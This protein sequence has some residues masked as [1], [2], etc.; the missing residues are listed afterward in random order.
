[1]RKIL[2]SAV[3][4]IFSTIQ[5]TA[6]QKW[7]RPMELKNCTIDIKADQFTATTFIEMEFCNP[8]NSEIEG[9]HRFK[10]KPGQIITAFQ[11]DLNGKYRD[12]SIEEKW[13]A[14]NAYNS[15]VGKRIDPALLTMDYAGHYTL[16]IYPVPAKGC[17]KVTM[18]IQ[19]LLTTERKNL[20]YYLPLN[21]ND[22]VQNFRLNISVNGNANPFAKTGLIA[23]RYFTGTGGKYTLNWNTENIL[24]KNPIA[25]SMP[26]STKPEIC[27]RTNE[28]QTFFALRLQ[29]SF[30]REYAIQPKQLTVFWD[31][32]ASLS[33]R[34]VNKEISFLKQFISRHNIAQLTIIP[35]NYK[36]L[37]S[38]IFF[39][40]NGFNSR[41]Q[42]YL[43]NITYDGATQLGIIDLSTI[44]SDIVLLFTDGNNTYGKSKPKTGNTIV[45]C[46]HTSSTANLAS[47]QQIV[48][49]SG[50]KVIDLNRTSISTAVDIGSKSENWLLNITSVAGKTIVEQAMPVKQEGTLFINGTMAPGTDTL[51]FLY[52]SNGRVNHIEKIAIHSNAECPSS[53]IDRINMLNNFDYIIRNYSWSNIIDFGIQEKVVTPHTAYIVLERV[54][55]YVK[56]NIAPP[57][58]LEAECEKMNYVKRDTRFERKK[59]EEAGEFDILK[60]VVNV[61]NERIKRWDKKENLL[62]LDKSEYE[63]F[64]DQLTDRSIP[65]NNTATANSE[66]SGKAAGLDMR[67]NALEEVVVI[68]YGTMKRKDLTGSVVQISSQNLFSSAT[69]V[70]QALQGRVP[71]LQITNSSGMPGSAANI[72]IR[73]ISSFNNNLPLY[74]LD[75]IPVSGNINDLVNVNDID[76]IT[77]LKDHSA[78]A[79]YGSRAANGAI[80]I[81]TK[82]GKNNYNRYNSKPYRL[83]D[84]EDVEYLQELKMV[85][86]TE[87]MAVY[88]KLKEQY[89]GEAGFYLDAAQYFFETGLTE[90]A[91]DILMNAAEA[92]NGSEQVL[93]AIAYILEYWKQYAEVIN[94]YEQLIKD[95]PNNLNYRRDLAWT[96]YLSGN[97]QQSINIFYEAIKMNTGQ[98]ANTTL[99][100]KAQL[101]NE[102]NAIISA[103]KEKLDISGIPRALIKSLP[104]DL[105][106]VIDCNKG[107]VSNASIKEPGNMVCNY[108]EPVTKNGGVI[109]QADYWYYSNPFEYQIK[110]APE[111]KYRISVSYYDYY[112]YQ[113]KIPA[114]IRI[115]TFKNFGKANQ[116]VAIEN[117]MM[118]N[119][120]G[121]IE[122]AEVKW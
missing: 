11:L 32:S 114:V 64:S 28:K 58:E 76:F 105:R 5:V 68:G 45:S 35:F 112:S 65:P 51:Y 25:I 33:K 3:L 59:T 69:S 71:G 110:R 97:Y 83:K 49:A 36:L 121:E 119:Q 98:Q 55:D 122:I 92:G 117:I 21:I 18:T 118:D 113:G 19:E 88:E 17:R 4:S 74:V 70:E 41:W 77:V 72:T 43:Q 89:G 78:S 46:I 73:G 15:I 96:H 23:D 120:Y 60:N 44:S 85:S 106:I 29:P 42:Q 100:L 81:N 107:N 12:G 75:G 82:R 14:T 79:L 93:V 13:K 8:N 40:G 54:E 6:Q 26:L 104:A 63:N 38:A 111:G 62:Y 48:G 67:S 53:V 52:G 39:T 22:T 37:D 61:Y 84:M 7:D 56:Y 2:L 34:D 47:L 20:Q 102:M 16:R 108:S 87:K 116:S 86:L 1:M 101:M 80:V 57:K 24:L 31:A 27:T 94:I 90:R 66:L 9:L 115:R 99:Y 103:H 10:L 95:N 50:G 30:Q 91:F 109:Q